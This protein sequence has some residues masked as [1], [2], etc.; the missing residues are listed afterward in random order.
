[1]NDM[2]RTKNLLAKLEEYIEQ[3]ENFKNLLSRKVET[4]F[5]M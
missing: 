5:G 3:S 2:H 1:M 4:R